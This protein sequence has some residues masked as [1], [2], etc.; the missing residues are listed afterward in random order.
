MSLS[1]PDVQ[2]SIATSATPAA[3]FLDLPGA[4]QRRL[5][6]TLPETVQ[7]SVVDDMNTEQLQRFVRRLDPDEA[8]D[9]LGF[10]VLLGLATLVV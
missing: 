6:F 8:T 9:V 2:Q 1:P 10:F 7:Q 5:F 4:Q 3:Q